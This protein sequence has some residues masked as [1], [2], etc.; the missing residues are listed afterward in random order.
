MP[1]SSAWSIETI[2]DLYASIEDKALS[3]FA[4]E[5]IAGVGA[6]FPVR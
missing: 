6:K 5:D 4:R 2:S 3:V 1:G